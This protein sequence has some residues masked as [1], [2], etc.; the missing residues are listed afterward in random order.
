MMKQQIKAMLAAAAVFICML[1]CVISASAERQF[2]NC[3]ANCALY[4]PDEIFDEVERN[5]ISETILKTSSDIDMYVAVSILDKS[6]KGLSDSAVQRM[7]DDLYDELFNP[8]YGEDSDG[9]LLLLNLQTRYMYISTSGMGQLYY[10]NEISNDRTA[11]MI[12]DM[13]PMLQDKDYSRAISQFCAD[14]VRY[15]QKGVPYGAYTYDSAQGVYYYSVSGELVSGSK[16]PVWYG[17][18]IVGW[19]IG[20]VC[21]GIA[22]WLIT[23]FC[24]RSSYRLR[25]SISATNYISQRDTDYYVKDDIYIRT[26]ETKRYVGSTDSG[27]GGF[28]GGGSSHMSSG[29]HSHGGGGGHW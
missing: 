15:Y 16:L 24:I 11:S 25:K 26:Y 17:K 28:S 13:R 8:Q 12:A 21:V 1:A 7:A 9:I 10:Y 4:D 29:G 27:G 19:G 2:E 22:A 18:H 6:G 14:A 5:Y 23:F 20:G 3:I